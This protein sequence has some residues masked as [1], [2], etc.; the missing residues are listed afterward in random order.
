M[1][2]LNNYEYFLSGTK[3]ECCEKFYTWNVIKC[4]GATPILAN[5]NGGYYP[6]WESSSSSGTC[7]ND[8]NVPTYMISNQNY[9]IFDTLEKC[10]NK[11]FSWNINKCLGTSSTATGTNKWYVDWTDSKCVQDCVGTSQSCGGIAEGWDELHS[12]QEECCE[13]KLSWLK[14][15]ECLTS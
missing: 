14:K 5:P 4:T 6:D 10:C 3:E 11:H 2:M 8:G 9:Y 7:L 1:Y 12:S 13:K 15:R